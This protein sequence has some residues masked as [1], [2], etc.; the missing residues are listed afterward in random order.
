MTDGEASKLL[1][2]FTFSLLEFER[3]QAKDTPELVFGI[4]AS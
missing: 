1:S 4:D 3:R 2:D